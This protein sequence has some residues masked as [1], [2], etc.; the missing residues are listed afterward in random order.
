[1]SGLFSNHLTTLSGT[2]SAATA[3]GGPRCDHLSLIAAPA[4]LRAI[5]GA[6]HIIY[7][8][9]GHAPHWEAPEQVAQDIVAFLRDQGSKQWTRD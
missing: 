4:L 3:T 9:I 2:A 8:A 1:M 6:R 5:P 7:P